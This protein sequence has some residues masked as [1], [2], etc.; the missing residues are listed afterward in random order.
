[1]IYLDRLP[2]RYFWTC[3]KKSCS[4]RV[5]K[6][7][8]S[9][10]EVIGYRSSRGLVDRKMIVWRS[11]VVGKKFFYRSILDQLDLYSISTRSV[12]D[13][14]DRYSICCPDQLD[15]YPIATRSLL[16]HTRLHSTATRSPTKGHAS[17]MIETNPL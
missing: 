8:R 9:D 13:Q 16:D 1:V 4:D 17:N 12:P 3:P 11:S 10:R 7:S 2:T 5:A 15:R 6:R 14:R